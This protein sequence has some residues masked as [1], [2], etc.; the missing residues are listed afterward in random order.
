MKGTVAPSQSLAFG[1]WLGIWIF[2]P[3]SQEWQ[4]RAHREVRDRPVPSAEHCTW[5]CPGSTS[6][7]QWWRLD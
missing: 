5:G 3:R 1:Q 6:E 4:E 2:L 7:D